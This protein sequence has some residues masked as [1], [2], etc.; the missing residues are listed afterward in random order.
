MILAL[1][2]A[3]ICYFI[4]KL[5]ADK[6]NSDTTPIVK[7]KGNL[8]IFDTETNGLPINWKAQLNDIDN[9]PRIIS[10][11]WNKIAP[12][13]TILSKH[14]AILKPDNYLIST[15]SICIHGITNEFAKKNGFSRKEIFLLFDKELDDCDYLV[16]H[17]I[18]FD[19]AV[20]YAEYVRLSK[21]V[22]TLKTKVKICT[23]KQATD[24]C[25]IPGK[26]G[27]KYPKIDEL[28]K[29]LFSKTLT[30]EHNAETNAYTCMICLKELFNRKIIK[31]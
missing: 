13:G 15:D 17:N 8:L 1:F 4:A 7:P 31:F 22:L 21:D 12:D 16:A 24:F 27:Y 23:M 30:A 18:E 11:A 25:K 20:I 28:Y 2:V 6:R 14:N 5:I 10:I 9:W 3:L 26:R 19:F 29:R